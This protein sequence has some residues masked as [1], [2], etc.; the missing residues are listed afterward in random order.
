M[1]LLFIEYP[2][3]SIC[4]KAKRW[5]DSRAIA[6][7]DRH[8]VEENPTEEELT[9]WIQK[10][11]MP[12]K[13]FWNTSGQLYRQMELSRKL[14]EMSPEDQIKLLSTNGMLC[15]RPILVGED[16]VLTGFREKEWEE[17]VE[18]ENR[19]YGG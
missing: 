17:M 16:F 14:P 19:S 1:A 3:C 18:V 7:E 11:G 13:K 4:Q 2:K 6:Y 9:A 15:K 8:I 5:L 10:S 12:I